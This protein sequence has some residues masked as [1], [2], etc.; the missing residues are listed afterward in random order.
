MTKK[1]KMEKKLPQR[2]PSLLKGKRAG[3]GISREK[4]AD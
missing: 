4:I 1:K 2:D 3:V